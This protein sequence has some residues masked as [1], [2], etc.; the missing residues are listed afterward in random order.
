MTGTAEPCSPYP[1]LVKYIDAEED[2]SIQV[3]PDDAYAERKGLQDRGKTECWYIV[4][5]LPSTEIIYGLKDE[6]TH[7]DLKAALAQNTIGDVVRRLP[8]KTGDFLFVPPGTVHAILGG[9]FLCEIQQSSDLTFR[10]WDWNRMPARTLHIEESLEVISY[11]NFGVK[12]VHEPPLPGK[13]ILLI[14]NSFFKVTVLHLLP[15][16]SYTIA[17]PGH[18]LILNGV[19]GS[20]YLE[21]T[22]LTL[23]DTFF[24]PACIPTVEVKGTDQSSTILMSHIVGAHGCVLSVSPV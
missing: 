2:L 13:P 11:T 14:E 20:C 10:L 23:G 19:G 17:Q 4:D 21:D 7:E 3:H 5:C 6:I 9:T 15:H 1:L 24:I 12:V 22:R 16:G 8:I 18:G